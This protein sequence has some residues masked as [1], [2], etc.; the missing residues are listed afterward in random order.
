MFSIEEI[1]N[2]MNSP[3]KE[4]SDLVRRAYDFA[5]KAHKG[6]KRLSGDDYIVHLIETAKILAS[7]KMDASTIAT[8]L[9]H[10][11]IEDGLATKE[12]IQKVFGNEILFLVNGVGKLGEIKYKGA[13]RHAEGMRKL[14]LAVSE[15]MRVLM[16]KL[17]DRLHNMKTLE[18]VP[19]EK[20]R[21]IA[22]ETFEIYAPIAYRLGISKLSKE[23]EDVAFK[24][25]EPEE[26][27]KVL[28]IIKERSK[29]DVKYL[30]KIIKSLKKAVAKEGIN[31][32]NTHYRVKGAKSFHRKIL[33]KGVE[34]S[35]HDILALRIIVNSIDDCYKT[36]GII[37]GQWRPVPG[38]IRDFI[39]LP[40]LNGYRSL[41][42]TV[43]TG[44][45]NL[46]EIQIRTEEM[47]Q[48]AEYGVAAHS[49]YK[50]HKTIEAPWVKKFVEKRDNKIEDTAPQWVKDLGNYQKD[51]KNPSSFIKDIKRDFFGERIFVLTPDGDVVD[52]PEKSSP[53]DFAY[54]IHSDIGNHI[55]GIKINGKM[56]SLEHELQNGDII[57]IMT[58]KSACP[59]EKWLKLV[60]TNNAKRHIRVA[61]ENKKNTK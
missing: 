23:L 2:L 13:K 34:E 60:K 37:H 46:V 9:L 31:V 18:Y 29:K 16:I 19:I 25:L 45:G 24:F 35:I 15:D 53:I 61:L 42:T 58:K 26:Y 36:L 57:E 20:Q 21:R 8:G 10:D 33:R 3:T 11:S 51:N 6:H 22:L 30:E 14:F 47:H 56:K 54:M 1:L 43:F 50:G 17:A 49:K 12:D 28:K 52:L 40:K 39:A 55:S 38:R 27:N 7:Y 41:Q 32:L 48:E 4:E 5:N 44:N 59:T